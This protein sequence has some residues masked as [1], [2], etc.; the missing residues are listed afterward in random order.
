MFYFHTH[1]NFMVGLYT[2]LMVQVFE[3]SFCIKLFE[4]S[5]RC[6]QGRC[7]VVRI[8]NCK[9]FYKVATQFLPLLFL[10]SYIYSYVM[11][12]R[13]YYILIE[14]TYNNG[15]IE[16]QWIKKTLHLSHHTMYRSLWWKYL[17]VIL[18]NLTLILL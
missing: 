12:C 16:F 18:N 2:Y 7:M 17:S 1:Q 11:Q 3:I 4:I 5:S 14:H 9:E 13:E 10:C 6:I 15:K 8:H